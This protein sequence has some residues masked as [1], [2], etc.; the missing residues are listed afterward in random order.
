[1]SS[2]KSKDRNDKLVNSLDILIPCLD[3]SNDDPYEKSLGELLTEIGINKKDYPT[4]LYNN[5]CLTENLTINGKKCQIKFYFGHYCGYLLEQP[6]NNYIPHGGFTADKGFDCMHYSD[7]SL[8]P[9]LMPLN[10]I[11]NL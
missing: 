7:L 1:M 8:N 5:D 4:W 11:K 6:T 3:N 10:D 2:D 9:I